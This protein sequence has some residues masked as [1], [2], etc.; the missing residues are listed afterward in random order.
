MSIKN[1]PSF[2]PQS[3][4]LLIFVFL[5]T[6]CTPALTEQ[7]PTPTIASS[8]TLVQIPTATLIALPVSPVPSASPIATPS[9]TPV[10]SLTPLPDTLPVFPLDGY[11]MLFT[12]DGDL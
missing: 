10:P 3:Y 9:R 6:A 11:V 8:T 7:T 2:P 1:T 4:F 12:K 5:L